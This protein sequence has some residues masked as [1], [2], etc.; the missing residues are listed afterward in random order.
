MLIG[1]P[2]AAILRIILKY[3]QNIP[4]MDQWG[5]PGKIIISH[6]WGKLSL[7]DFFQPHNESIKAFSGLIW[8]LLSLPAGWNPRTE[9]VVT[10]LVTVAVAVMLCILLRKTLVSMTVVR[11]AIFFLMVLFLFHPYGTRHWLIGLNLENALVIFFL[12]AG[13]LVNSSSAP[14]WSKYVLAASF[15]LAATFSYANGM[16]LWILICPA[17]PSLSGFQKRPA[18]GKRRALPGLLYLAAGLV[19]ILIFLA[20]S[21][22]NVNQRSV[23][24]LEFDKPLA[25]FVF[26]L[27]W[28]GAPFQLAGLSLSAPGIASVVLLLFFISL[29]FTLQ[30]LRR[31]K[32]CAVMQPWI[33][34]ALYPLIT[35]AAVACGR[36]SDGLDKALA[37][38]Y[39]LN[40]VILPIAVL[41]LV[42][43]LLQGRPAY[44]ASHLFSR[45]ILF[46]LTGLMVLTCIA[47]V[48]SQWPRAETTAKNHANTLIHGAT[49]L[50]FINAVPNNP[51]LKILFPG[52]GKLKA[53]ARILKNGGILDFPLH[54][55]IPMTVNRPNEIHIDGLRI[56]LDQAGGNLLVSAVCPKSSTINS[57]SHLLL[58]SIHDGRS[59]TGFSVTS[60]AGSRMQSGFQRHTQVDLTGLER[61][62]HLVKA[63]LYDDV[64][65]EYRP[66]DFERAFLYDAD[67]LFFFPT[68]SPRVANREEARQHF[69]KA[70]RTIL[71]LEQQE[72][73][74]RLTPVRG[75][76][77]EKATLHVEGPDPSL[78]LPEFSCSAEASAAVHLHIM[79]SNTTWVQL[80]YRYDVNEQFTEQDS[81]WARVREGENELYFTV[82]G[83]N[84]KD[85][86]RFDPGDRGGVYEL[87]LLEVREYPRDGTK[88]HDQFGP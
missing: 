77:L 50:S 75:V 64:S 85:R 56:H 4:W 25:A 84:L 60:L 46:S 59:E 19:C 18:R 17:L 16:L 40:P 62:L 86:W 35:G 88:R 14:T 27:H 58:T 81:I 3:G 36:L 23:R 69:E 6:H 1:L 76:T 82:P 9:M 26:L 32:D 41:P 42:A 43:L 13:L 31:G 11:R 29:L 74:C 37:D 10:W 30:R 39:F 33:L 71:R 54:P 44:R 70:D 8:F 67:G 45:V 73:A 49:A 20:I 47:S 66:L 65:S 57:F 55:P 63:W 24:N 2:P 21:M 34:M 78:L 87:R 72:L 22:D 53:Q 12:A 28:L 51:K 61:G 80:F 52:L 48:L 5:V 68:A 79:A 38:R 83:P 15:S 7:S